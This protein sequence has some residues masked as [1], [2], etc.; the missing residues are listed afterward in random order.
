MRLAV[1]LLTAAC[2]FCGI[3]GTGFASPSIIEQIKHPSPR[4]KQAR[5]CTTTCQWIGNQQICNTHCF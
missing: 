4:E 5:N 3:G 2:F 1:S